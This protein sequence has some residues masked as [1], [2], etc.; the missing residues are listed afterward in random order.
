MYY[1]LFSLSFIAHFIR[2]SLCY[3]YLYRSSLFYRSSL[4]LLFVRRSFIAPLFTLSSFVHR[5]FHS[6]FSLSLGYGWFCSLVTMFLAFALF[7]FSRFYLLSSLVFCCY[8]SLAL[9]AILYV[10]R[11]L[12]SMFTVLC[13][14]IIR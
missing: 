14:L 7:M 8:L 9:L 12:S 2:S 6:L 11:S 1:P 13:Y 5:S 10:Y 4:Y 3:L